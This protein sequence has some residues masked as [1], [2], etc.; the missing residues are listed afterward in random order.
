MPRPKPNYTVKQYQEL[1][2]GAESLD[3]LALIREQMT[4]DRDN[5]CFDPFQYI[6][7]MAPFIMKQLSL[8]IEETERQDE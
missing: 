1:I 6:D 7:L 2:A 8:T 5:R 3:E 4:E